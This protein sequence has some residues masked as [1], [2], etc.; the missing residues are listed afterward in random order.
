MNLIQKL[1][2]LGAIAFILFMLPDLVATP[3]DYRWFYY[4][5]LVVVAYA[6][7]LLFK[8]S[9]ESSSSGEGD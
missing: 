9:S 7:W 2:I 3:F 1:I 4:A 6:V 8:A 5:A